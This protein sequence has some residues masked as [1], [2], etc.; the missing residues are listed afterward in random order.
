MLLQFGDIKPF[1][2]RNPDIGPSLR[3]KL[4]QMITDVNTLP[5]LQMELA[6]IVDV[7]E[8]FVKATYNLEG[9]GALVLQCYEEIVKVRVALQAAHYPN[10]GSYCSTACSRKYSH[11][12][13]VDDIWNEL[14]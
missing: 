3:P 8:Y 13:A 9:D 6:T 12:A 5:Y 1:L 10:Y 7:G 2:T 14:C 4:L 11:T